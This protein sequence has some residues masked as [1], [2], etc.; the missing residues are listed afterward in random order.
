M[1]PNRQAAE[2]SF[3]SWDGAELFYRAWLPE[4]ATDRAVILFHRGH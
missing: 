1:H 2:H 3:R 4:V